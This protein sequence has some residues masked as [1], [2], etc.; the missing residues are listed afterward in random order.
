MTYG[1]WIKVDSPE[2]LALMKKQSDEAFL[3]EVARD[4]EEF[5]ERQ[6][7]YHKKEDG[8]DDSKI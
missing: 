6:D 7:N 5:F 2:Y 8:T 3:E 1:R 4:A